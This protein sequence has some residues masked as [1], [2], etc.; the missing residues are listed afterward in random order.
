M[1]Q[2]IPRGLEVISGDAVTDQAIEVVHTM[3]VAHR[4]YEMEGKC[5]N[6]HGHSMRVRLTIIGGL[7]EHGVLAGL[8]FGSVKYMF[9]SWI[10]DHFDHHLLLN[11]KDYLTHALD[12]GGRSFGQLPGLMV[13]PE[14]PTTENISKWIGQWAWGVFACGAPTAYTKDYSYTPE[15]VTGIRIQVDE[16]PTNSGFWL[17][18][19]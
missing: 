8:Q 9:R 17:R 5:Q 4:L 12:F 15:M 11:E 3:E 10:D 18:T 16:T 14:D 6:I 2:P 13:M 1:T 7:D 19:R